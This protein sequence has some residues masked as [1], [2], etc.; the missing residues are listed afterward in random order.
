M[1]STQHIPNNTRENVCGHLAL[2]RIFG[3]KRHKVTRESQRNMEQEDERDGHIACV[4]YMRNTK[5]AGFEVLT[6]VIMKRH[7]FWDITPCS[8]FMND[9]SEKHV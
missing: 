2:R 6:P 8:L 1:H 5:C 9:V 7:F 4:E 3:Q